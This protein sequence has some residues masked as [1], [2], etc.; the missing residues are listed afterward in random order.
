MTYRGSEHDAR[1]PRRRSTPTL[2]DVADFYA[3]ASYGRISL[4]GVVTPPV[5]LPHNEAWYVNRDTSNGGDI[6][7]EGIEHA[8]AR[9]EARKL[10]FDST[11]YDCIVV[12]HNGG[13]GSYG[14]LGRRQ[15]RVGARRR[16]VAL[17][18]RDRALLRPRARELL[19][20]GRHQRHRRGREPGIRRQLRQH[21]RRSLRRP[22]ITMR[23]RK[24]RSNGCRPIS[25]CRA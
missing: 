4:V 20:H 18:A 23:R 1:A 11:D 2:R 21:G 10:G 19:G 15:Q 12:R 17:G 25:L 3:K 24:A 14:G 5:K 16:R 8:H 13:P 7:G 22:G 9:E 6:D